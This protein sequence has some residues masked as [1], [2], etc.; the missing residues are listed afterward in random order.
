VCFCVDELVGLDCVE[1]YMPYRVGMQFGIDQGVPPS[2]FTVLNP[3]DMGNFS[4]YVPTRCY[5]PCVSLEY[6]NWWKKLKADDSDLL[7]DKNCML[8]VVM[9]AKQYCEEEEE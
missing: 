4:F 6:H 1:K 7:I 2:E 5:K 8:D 3:S 9:I